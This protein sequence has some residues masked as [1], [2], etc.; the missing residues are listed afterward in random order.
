[1]QSYLFS[2]LRRFFLIFYLQRITSTAKE[3]V[4][5][6]TE[7]A[8]ACI[9]ELLVIEQQRLIFCGVDYRDRSSKQVFI[10]LPI[11]N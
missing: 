8:D 3:E 6:I 11:I 5:R 2:I 7:S 4:K 1:M 9:K 10:S